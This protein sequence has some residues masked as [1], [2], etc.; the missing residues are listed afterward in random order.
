MQMDRVESA[1]G[2]LG[3]VLSAPRSAAA[4]LG[5]GGPWLATSLAQARQVLSDPEAFDFPGN[6]NRTGD[7]SGSRG[8]T[9]SGHT[10]FTPVGPDDVG[11]G[12]ATF[13][14]EWAVALAE[15]QRSRPGQAYDAMLLLRRP[16]ARATTTAL[17]PSASDDVRDRVGDH[18]LAWIDALAP[19]IAARRPPARW[20]RVRRAERDTRIALEDVLEEVLAAD[21]APDLS[22][23]QAAT[24]L[25]AGIQV[26]IAAGAF[27]IAWLAEQ[28]NAVDPT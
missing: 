6:V 28:A 16:V 27:L 5:P 8:N 25:A 15:H 22:P 21:A 9:R 19:V 20:G 23:Q 11:R 3:A 7:L 13:K 24:M 1:G 4:A 18:V 12:V 14:R 10:T 17:L 26:P 2:Q